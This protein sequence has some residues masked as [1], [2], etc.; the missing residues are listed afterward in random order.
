MVKKILLAVIVILFING[1]AFSDGFDTGFGFGSAGIGLDVGFE[2]FE[3][4]VQSSCT[5]IGLNFTLF[6]YS[7][8]F[9]YKENLINIL[10]TT[11]YW[12]VVH[13]DPTMY[14][15]GPYFSIYPLNIYLG[16]NGNFNVLVFEA[17]FKWLKFFGI[18]AGYKY[19][20][21]RHQAVFMFNVTYLGLLAL[22]ISPFFL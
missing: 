14:F 7:Y 19:N 12:N 9:I 6:K 16:S 1:I 21:G 22:G 5:T 18:E 4:Y 2:L 8:S 10:K 11:L 15:L 3:L 17:G 20:N 13:G